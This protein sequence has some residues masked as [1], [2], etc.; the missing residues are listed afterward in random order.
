MTAKSRANL[1]AVFQTGDKPDGDDFADLIDSCVNVTDTSAQTLAG[2]VTVDSLTATIVSAGTVNA[3]TLNVAGFTVSGISL[4]VVSAGD[5]FSDTARIVSASVDQLRVSALSTHKNPYAEAY[6]DLTAFTSIDAT[7]SWVQVCADL[8][9]QLGAGFSVSG[10]DVKYTGTVTAKFVVEAQ[11]EG[12]V[13][14][15]QLLWVAVTK[16]GTVVSGSVS[17][18]QPGNTNL[19]A[20]E[21][22]TV[23][24]LKANDNVSMKVQT[25]DGPIQRME[26][27]GVKYLIH[28]VY[29]G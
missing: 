1:K 4:A 27:F 16:N 29:W 8:T 5:L 13:S 19:A 28:P 17:K 26:T 18:R 15:N 12:R 6:A 22:R 3:D 14:A 11:I 23:V 21:T 9:S 24:E 25:P 10:H 20:F 2:N 7:A